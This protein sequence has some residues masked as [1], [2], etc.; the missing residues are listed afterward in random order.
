MTRLSSRSLLLCAVTTFALAAC[1]G[2]DD[3][4]A[5]RASK[6]SDQRCTPDDPTT[7]LVNEDSC[8]NGATC[9]EGVC[10]PPPPLEV[11]ITTTTSG[12]AERRCYTEDYWAYGACGSGASWTWFKVRRIAQCQHLG[13]VVNA[14]GLGAPC[15]GGYL[16][17]YMQCCEPKK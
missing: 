16:T 11:Q 2:V 10:V 17:A 9:I 5:T 6:L 15:S 13:W 1:G 14:N 4:P 3:G 7:P 12:F 8:S